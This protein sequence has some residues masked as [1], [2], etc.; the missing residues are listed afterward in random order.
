MSPL[1]F[2]AVTIF[3]MHTMIDGTVS[4]DRFD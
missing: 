4:I 1:Y 3:E 2:F